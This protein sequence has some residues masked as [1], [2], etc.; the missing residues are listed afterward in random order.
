MSRLSDNNQTNNGN[1]QGYSRPVCGY[2]SRQGHL[3]IDCRT[4]QR[5]QGY[6]QYFQQNRWGQ[7]TLNQC[8]YKQNSGQNMQNQGQYRQ[9]ADQSRQ[10]QGQYRQ[11]GSQY[12]QDQR[13]LQGSC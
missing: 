5:E 6:D 8:Q 3:E 10:N 11:N 12:R 7:N 2:C 13:N 4:K 1:N 9:N